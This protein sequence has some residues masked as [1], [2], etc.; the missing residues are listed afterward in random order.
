[1][2]RAILGI[3]RA[4][5][6]AG[7]GFRKYKSWVFSNPWGLRVKILVINLSYILLYSMLT[8]IIIETKKYSNLGLKHVRHVLSTKK[9]YWRLK[10]CRIAS[11]TA[12]AQDGCILSPCCCTSSATCLGS[13]SL[14]NTHPIMFH[15]DY[16]IWIQ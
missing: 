3:S 6:N 15:V 4:S 1:M 2:Q 8:N 13:F 12:G 10:I 5:E 11:T 9:T 7:V 16:N 14:S